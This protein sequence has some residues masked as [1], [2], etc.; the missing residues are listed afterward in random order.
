MHPQDFSILENNEHSNK[1]NWNQIREL[2][3]ILD[4]INIQGLHIVPISKI[5]LDHD[6]I[7]QIP[8]WIKQISIWHSEGKISDVEYEN[9]LKFYKENGIISA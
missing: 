3:V 2:E 5:N 6:S 1:I 9:G 7:V 8:H 4:T